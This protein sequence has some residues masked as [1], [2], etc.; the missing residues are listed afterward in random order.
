MVACPYYF[1]LA[2]NRHNAVFS[3]RIGSCSVYLHFILIS[4]KKKRDYAKSVK[5]NDI[6]LIWKKQPLRFKKI[7]QHGKGV[8]K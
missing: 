3:R 5:I 2:D 6:R 1:F 8:I 7:F 4:E